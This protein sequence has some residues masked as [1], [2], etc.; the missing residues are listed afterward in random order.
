MSTDN[1]FEFEVRYNFAEDPAILAIK[2]PLSELEDLISNETGGIVITH[3]EVA[4]TLLALSADPKA[5]LKD[6]GV[7]IELL[8]RR[9]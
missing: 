9:P 7:A 3:A 5:P 6:R 2:I 1:H 8:K 4:E